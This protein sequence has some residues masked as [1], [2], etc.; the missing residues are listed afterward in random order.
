M[1]PLSENSREI[2]KSLIGNG[3]AILETFSP[4]SNQIEQETRE[5]VQ[6]SS[7]V[8]NGKTVFFPGLIEKRK[9]AMIE[10]VEKV[11]EGPVAGS[12]ALKNQACVPMWK[13]AYR[14]R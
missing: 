8:G 12:Q 9:K 13:S 5:T 10:D 7:F 3:L 6:F 11:S 14:P 2:K 1:R 4:Y